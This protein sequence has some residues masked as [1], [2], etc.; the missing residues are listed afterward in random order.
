MSENM[1]DNSGLSERASIKSVSVKWGLI[2]GAIGIVFYLILMLGELYTVTGVSFVGLIPFVIVIL[3]AMKE[4]K[5]NGDGYMSYGEGLKIAVL[6]SLIGGAMLAVFSLIYTQLIDTEMIARMREEVV[7][8]LEEQG[9]SDEEIE[10]GMK[11]VDVFSNPY[12]G[13][14]LTIIKNVF[15]G[16]ILSLVISAIAKNNNPELEV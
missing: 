6:I 3:M 16:F 11:F 10:M 12:L 5:A 2:S 13:F 14:I 9:K 1:L 8:K 4:F 7:M 15:V